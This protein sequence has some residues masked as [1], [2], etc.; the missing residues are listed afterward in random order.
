MARKDIF[1]MTQKELNRVSI[2][3]NV[4]KKVI[5]QKKAA[6][7]LDLSDR[8]IRRIVKRV[9]EEGNKGLIHKSRGRHGHRAIPKDVKAKVLELCQKRYK[10]FG[11]TLAVEKLSEIDRLSLSRETLRKWLIKEG[12]SYKR[13][14][15]RPHKKWRERKQHYGEMVQMD[16]SHHDWLEGRRPKACAYGL[17]R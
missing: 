17:H 9:G 11:P 13:R 8:Q 10:G 16:G 1:R 7:I 4:L 14:K 3:N 5:T 12:L 15:N 2:I 6:D